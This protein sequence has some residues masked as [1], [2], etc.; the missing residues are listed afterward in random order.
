[1]SENPPPQFGLRTMLLA[2]T[3]L[4]A[5]C[6]LVAWCGLA[7][8]PGLVMVV[9][10]LATGAGA[11]VGLLICSYTGLGF[12]FGDL[13]SDALKCAALGAIIVL[14]AYGLISLF[15]TAFVLAPMPIVIGVC[16]KLFWLELTGIEMLIVGFSSLCGT[17]MAAGI[18]SYWM[19]A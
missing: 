19:G 4:A 1:M 3:A 15:H 8:G 9:V 11:F 12:G 17:S 2:M 10:V 13:T 14:L 5:L 7:G 16:I 6:G 18:A